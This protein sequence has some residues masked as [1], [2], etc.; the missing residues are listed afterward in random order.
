MLGQYPEDTEAFR[1]YGKYL[2][3]TYKEDLKIISQPIDFYCQNIYNG[4]LVRATENGHERLPNPMQT[5]M[6]ASKWPV[7]PKC[8]YWGPKFL[9]ERYGKPIIISENG[10]SCHDVISTDGNVHDDA[11]VEF[12]KTYLS[13][14]G[15]AIK[16][17]V[18]ITG[19]MYWSFLDNF[20][21]KEGYSQRFGLVYVNYENMERI[22]KDS[23]Y[24][25]QDIIANNGEGIDG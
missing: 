9:Y 24:W 8:L 12:M 21:W 7:T 16:D 5:P 4:Y 14:L 6:T 1:A 25:Y 11:R 23:F 19:Y 20:E 17:G 3:S 22:P 2:P 15:R 18:D 13:E 10:M